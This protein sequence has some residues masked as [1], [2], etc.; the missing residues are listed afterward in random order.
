V[1][2]VV[3]VVQLFEL[4]YA[5][6]DPIQD[7]FRVG[8]DDESTIAG[9]GWQWSWWADIWDWNGRTGGAWVDG[10][11]VRGLLEVMLEVEIMTLGY[12]ISKAGENALSI[13]NS[14]V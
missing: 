1:P 13:N 8:N 12:L 10:R 11:F 4:D 3:V 14:K 9:Y 6:G 2:V 5:G 7:Q